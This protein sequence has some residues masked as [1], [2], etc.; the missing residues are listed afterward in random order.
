MAG[1][2]VS[3]KSEQLAHQV[4]NSWVIHIYEC[5]DTQMCACMLRV[6]ESMQNRGTSMRHLQLQLLTFQPGQVFGLCVHFPEQDLCYCLHLP[7]ITSHATKLSSMCWDCGQLGHNP[8]YCQEDVLQ[9]R[10]PLLLIPRHD[11]ECCLLQPDWQ[12]T[13]HMSCQL[14]ISFIPLANIPGNMRLQ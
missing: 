14:G 11:A 6:Q 12:H 10:K 4:P 9:Q 3:N 1:Q 7:D 5:K 13:M 2:H 8:C